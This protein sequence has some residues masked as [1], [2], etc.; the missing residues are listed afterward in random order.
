MAG[1][2]HCLNVAEHIRAASGDAVNLPFATQHC[3]AASV[4]M[5]AGGHCTFAIATC[6]LIDVVSKSHSLLHPLSG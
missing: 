3:I 4:V 2:A 5:R 1:L 6:S